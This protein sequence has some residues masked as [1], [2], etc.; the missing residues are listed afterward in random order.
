MNDKA[1]T[2][3]AATPDSPP[4][5]WTRWVNGACVHWAARRANIKPWNPYDDYDRYDATPR[6]D[7]SEDRDGFRPVLMFTAP[8]QTT[9]SDHSWTTDEAFAS[10]ETAFA[11]GAL[12]AED[13]AGGVVL[14]EGLTAA[15]RRIAG[16]G[17]DY[18]MRSPEAAANG[19]DRPATGTGAAPTGVL[20]SDETW[21]DLIR[22]RGRLLDTKAAFRDV[23][24]DYHAAGQDFLEALQARDSAVVALAAAAENHIDAE[25]ADNPGRPGPRQVANRQVAT[26]R[27]LETSHRAVHRWARENGLD[28]AGDFSYRMTGA[29]E[30]TVTAYGLEHAVV[31]Q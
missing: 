8:N 20:A 27:G 14:R 21:A 4:R 7:V 18:A 23:F 1:D 28:G 5:R 15:A 10:W 24:D 31:V 26:R 19:P 11:V 12:E 2:T 29:G 22:A 17:F 25:Q 3:G 30:F 13:E 9:I 16:P 6:L